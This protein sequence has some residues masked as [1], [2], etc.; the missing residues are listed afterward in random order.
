MEQRCSIA[1][2]QSW[3]ALAAPDVLGAITV[4]RLAGKDR[5]LYSPA[6]FSSHGPKRNERDH[7]YQ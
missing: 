2:D 7:G 4:R 6:G 5:V 1:V 3:A